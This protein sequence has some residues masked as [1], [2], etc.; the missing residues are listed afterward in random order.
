[1]KK[2]V[3]TII[4]SYRKN[5]AQLATQCPDKAIDYYYIYYNKTDGVM[6]LFSIDNSVSIKEY[7]LINRYFTTQWER[8]YNI[9]CK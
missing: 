5:F 9:Y 4:R 6:T 1:M 3:F 2:D 8:L 7:M